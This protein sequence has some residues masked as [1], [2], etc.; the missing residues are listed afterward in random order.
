VIDLCEHVFTNKSNGNAGRLSVP[1][2]K[3]C[4]IS[5]V[6]VLTSYLIPSLNVILRATRTALIIISEVM[7]C[8]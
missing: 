7:F 1:T 2:G 4:E 6:A 8:I 3:T 5:T